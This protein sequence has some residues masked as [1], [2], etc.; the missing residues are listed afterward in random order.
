MTTR[1]ELLLEE[2]IPV[3]PDRPGEAHNVWTQQEQ[4]R[5]WADL[6]DAIGAPVALRPVTCADCGQRVQPDRHGALPAHNCEV[7]A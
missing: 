2:S 5:H 7:A 3:R 4:D 6:A 1:L